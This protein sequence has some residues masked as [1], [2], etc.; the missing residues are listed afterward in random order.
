MHMMILGTQGLHSAN[1]LAKYSLT[2]TRTTLKMI[3]SY[4][5]AKDSVEISDAAKNLSAG[6]Q[7]SSQLNGAN[8]SGNDA[9]GLANPGETSAQNSVLQTA[10]SNGQ[11]SRVAQLLAENTRPH[12]QA[13]DLPPGL[14]AGMSTEGRSTMEDVDM[15]QEML[16]FSREQIFQQSGMA[17]M[18]QSNSAPQQ[19]LRLF[20]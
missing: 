4:V 2:D 1:L 12:S 6:L 3:G 17:M 7:N 11:H 13:P 16:T 8:L 19:I 5:M 15:G 20:G 10:S 9:S 18:L 14:A